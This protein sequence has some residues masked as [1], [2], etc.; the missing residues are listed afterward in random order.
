MVR[1]PFS[2]LLPTTLRLTTEGGNG[3][4]A[5]P[6]HGYVYEAD[7]SSRSPPAESSRV[8]VNRDCGESNLGRQSYGN[9]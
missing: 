7:R 4:S 9:S 2:F 8:R 5:A 1:D 3:L 6:T